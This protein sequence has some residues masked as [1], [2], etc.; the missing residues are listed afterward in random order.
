MLSFK[1]SLWQDMVAQGDLSPGLLPGTLDLLSPTSHHKD[2]WVQT[3]RQP[4][5]EIPP[6]SIHPS[7]LY[8]QHSFDSLQAGKRT[9]WVL[10]A[11]PESPGQGLRDVHLGARSLFWR[12]GRSH[13]EEGCGWR[14]ARAESSII[15]GH[16][17]RAFWL[18]T[19]GGRC[20][21]PWCTAFQSTN[22]QLCSQLLSV[23]ISECFG[24]TLKSTLLSK[25]KDFKWRV[26]NV[27]KSFET[28]LS[29]C[30]A[31]NN[32]VFNTLKSTDINELQ[33]LF[34]NV[35]LQRTFS[36]CFICYQNEM[37]NDFHVYRTITS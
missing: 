25:T 13:C 31:L 30:I 14:R 21:V 11:V 33:L 4:S 5:W 22:F 17:W 1:T 6:L 8:T 24:D 2:S 9:T 35:I 36:S 26:S 28:W 19:E 27:F 15:W 32:D 20:W 16:Q 37:Q 12:K 10:E 7:P 34:R 18:G 23:V 29:L 3:W